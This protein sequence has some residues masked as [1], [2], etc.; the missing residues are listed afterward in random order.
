M[1]SQSTWFTKQLEM[2]SKQVEELPEWARREA[3]L[4]SGNTSLKSPPSVNTSLEA[5][6][7]NIEP[8]KQG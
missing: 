7:G 2:V 6:Q 4:Q 8:P 1:N 3:G 5:G